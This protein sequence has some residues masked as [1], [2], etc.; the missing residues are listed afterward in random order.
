MSL[1]ADSLEDA[2][3][4]YGRWVTE[5]ALPLWAEAGLDAG[6]GAYLEGLTLEGRPTPGDRRARVQARQVMVY[7]SAARAGLGASWLAVAERGFAAYVEG[8]RRPDGRFAVLAD[9]AGRV[10][11]D[12]PRLYEQA[13]TLLA[14]AALHG[15]GARGFDHPAQAQRLL[16][17]LQ[18]QRHP[19]GGFRE[20]G[21]H[22]FQANSTMHL[23]EAALAW[24][25]LGVSAAWTGLADELAEL[26]LDRFIDAEGGFLREFFD[27]HW[28][29]AAGDDGRWVEPGHQFEWA[30]LL[31]RWGRARGQA[32][33]RA[34]ARTLFSHGLVGVDRARGVAMNRLWDD[35]SVRDAEAR[36]WPQAEYL[37]AA[38]IL[39]EDAEALVAANG[40]AKYL[41]VPLRGAWRDRLRPDGT[42]VDEPAPASSFYHIWMAIA[43]LMGRA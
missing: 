7:A 28:R 34:A 2:A 15:A 30:W 19:A 31:E 24:D 14:M 8:Y 26:C 29:P 5:A 22:P 1:S 41:D 42:F 9:A 21:E 23:L 33:A 25:E 40:L 12:T 4:G 35:L 36:L 6:S 38:L 10:L 13:F 16:D 20:F 27:E 43:E 17:A 3:L 32:R 37:K 18:G 39:G 11:D